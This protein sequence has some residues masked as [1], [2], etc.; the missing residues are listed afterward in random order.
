MNRTCH[1][2]KSSPAKGRASRCGP[3][4]STYSK[5]NYKSGGSAFT[6]AKRFREYRQGFLNSIKNLPCMDCEIRFPPECMDFDHRD[7]ELKSFVIDS[8]VISKS[9]ETLR[10]LMLEVSKCDLVCSNCHRIRTKKFKHGQY[11]RTEEQK[12]KN[13]PRP[14]I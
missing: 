1:I 6:S 9:P 14:S 13:N 11:R 12:S 2:C 10:R 4:G 3:C 7:P 5:A 8:K